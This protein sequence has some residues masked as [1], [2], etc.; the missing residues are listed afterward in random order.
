MEEL[1]LSGGCTV[2]GESLSDTEH[3]TEPDFTSLLCVLH[4]W[5]YCLLRFLGASLDVEQSLASAALGIVGTEAEGSM[6]LWIPE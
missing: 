3:L 5:L 6:G 4:I 2:G 1:G